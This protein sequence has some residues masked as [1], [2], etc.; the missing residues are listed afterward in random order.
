MI[1]RK[2][3]DLDNSTTSEEAADSADS[4]E[5]YETRNLS[6]GT[7]DVAC[8]AAITSRNHGEF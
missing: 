6:E 1:D 3:E 8:V 2:E 7:D 5:M 4:K